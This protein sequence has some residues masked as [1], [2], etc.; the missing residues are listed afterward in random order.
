M[1]YVKA[2]FYFFGEMPVVLLLMDIGIVSGAE[3]QPQTSLVI[4]SKIEVGVEHLL[5]LLNWLG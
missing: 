5:S 4:I 3:L 1:N 2:L